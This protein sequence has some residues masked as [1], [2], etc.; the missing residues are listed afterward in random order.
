MNIEQVRK[1]L[2]S[3]LN[4]NHLFLY[5]GSRGVHESFSGRII[6]IYPRTFLILTDQGSLKSFSYNDFII[7]SLKVLQ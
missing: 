7:R 4:Q 2:F 5:N 1:T 6:S 3:Y